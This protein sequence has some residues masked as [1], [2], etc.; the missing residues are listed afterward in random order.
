MPDDVVMTSETWTEYLAL[1][2]DN[3]EVL[4][5]IRFASAD[6]PEATIPKKSIPK[7]TKELQAVAYSVKA[8]R[9]PRAWCSY[10]VKYTAPAPAA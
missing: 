6:T 9:A 7:G 10:F 5:T 4:C 2:N 8:G 3:T 1:R